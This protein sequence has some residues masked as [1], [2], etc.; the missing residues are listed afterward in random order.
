VAARALILRSFYQDSMV[1]MRV[2][3]QLR[4]VPGVRETAALMGTAANQE[5]LAAAGL[6]TAGT[7]SASAADLILAVDTD[8]DAAADAAFA[9]A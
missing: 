4:A 6:A 2:A 8:D 7:R 9:A 1:L 5:L 3:E